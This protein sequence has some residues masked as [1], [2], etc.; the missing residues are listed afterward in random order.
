VHHNYV[1]TSIP[2]RLEFVDRHS[3]EELKIQTIVLP[4]RDVMALHGKHLLVVYFEDP[5]HGSYIQEFEIEV[6]EDGSVE[7]S[8][9]PGSVKLQ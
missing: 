6:R 7:F 4:F 3:R 9:E 1:C 8:S 5:S 2:E